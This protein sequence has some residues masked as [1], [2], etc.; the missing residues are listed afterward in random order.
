MANK[1]LSYATAHIY[2]RR[3]YDIACSRCNSVFLAVAGIFLRRRAFGSLDLK[4]R[5][6]ARRD[7]GIVSVKLG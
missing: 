3:L 7:C 6:S 5:L 1:W 4:N 2:S